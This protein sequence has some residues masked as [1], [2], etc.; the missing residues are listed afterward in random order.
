MIKDRKFELGRVVL[1]KAGRD[2][3]KLFVIIDILD[4]DYVR[5]ANGVNRTME[6]PK[7]KKIK[8]LSETPFYLEGI[9]QKLKEGIKIFDAELRKNLELLKEEE[10]K[11]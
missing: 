3:G 11:A 1:A 9:R 4:E 10:Y 5:I 6:K 8:H 7:M 2:K